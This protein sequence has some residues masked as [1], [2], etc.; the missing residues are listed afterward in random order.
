M[1]T[2]LLFVIGMLLGSTAHPDPVLASD[3]KTLSFSLPQ[4]YLDASANQKIMLMIKYKFYIS[5]QKLNTCNAYA[6]ADLTLDSDLYTLGPVTSRSSGTE[7]GCSSADFGDDERLVSISKILTPTGEELTQPRLRDLT[8]VV[9]IEKKNLSFL[10]QHRDTFYMRTEGFKKFQ[11]P[12]N[13][14]VE[15]IV[16][17]MHEEQ[18]TALVPLN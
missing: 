6:G 16:Y 14:R 17:E 3:I 11:V 12:E 9:R 1:K 15:A 7:R 8:D 18:A 10:Y 5:H 4:K 2:H 13:V